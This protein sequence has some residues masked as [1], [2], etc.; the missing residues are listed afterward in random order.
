VGASYF[1]IW[2]ALAG[3]RHRTA[4][5]KGEP[6]GLGDT[7]GR[8]PAFDGLGSDLT[9]RAWTG[10]LQASRDGAVTATVE[11]LIEIL[12]GEAAANAAVACRRPADLRPALEVLAVRMAAGEVPERLAG[13]RLVGAS[14]NALLWDANGQEVRTRRQ[15]H[16]RVQT[17][18][19]RMI[20][21]G[22]CVLAID[23]ATA[24]PGG[25]AGAMAAAA[26]LKDALKSGA[27]RCIVAAPGPEIADALSADAA[28]AA[29]F[30]GIEV[31]PTPQS[32]IPFQAPH[33]TARTEPVLQ[34]LL[35][36]R[37]RR[38]ERALIEAVRLANEEDAYGVG[39]EHLLAALLS[40]P[41]CRACRVLSGLGL[42]LDAID[43][44]VTAFREAL[45]GA[46]KLRPAEAPRPFFDWR[47]STLQAFALAITAAGPLG[48]LEVDSGHL[49]LGLLRRREIVV[50]AVLGPAGV[51]ADRFA[52]ALVAEPP[53]TNEDEPRS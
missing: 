35:Q 16:E 28:L 4:Q 12:G 22:D 48:T 46:G 19:G 11:Q 29:L 25:E 2:S 43:V 53:E 8:I 14:F 5:N 6:A 49:L 32:G 51:T 34:E 42:D 9:A 45:K 33:A 18:V 24:L 40:D 17:L 1:R 20:E 39:S 3:E 37:T 7:E 47:Q 44:A 26:G 10:A 38:A 27:L 21:A 36:H 13:T 31:S 15:F 30:T 23:G 50:L 41:S 52:E